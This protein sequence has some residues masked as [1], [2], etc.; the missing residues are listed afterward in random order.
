MSFSPHRGAHTFYMMLQVT[1]A[2]GLLFPRY[3][4]LLQTSCMTPWPGKGSIAWPTQDN[5]KTGV[6]PL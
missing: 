6:H 4:I 3:M 1:K 5:T 2:K